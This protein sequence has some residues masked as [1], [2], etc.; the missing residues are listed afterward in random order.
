MALICSRRSLVFVG[1]GFC[2]QY[3][4]RSPVMEF[5]GREGGSEW[6][7]KD[8]ILESTE[9]STAEYTPSDVSKVAAF[10]KAPSS[11]RPC[12]VF[13][14]GNSCNRASLE[15]LVFLK[16]GVRWED[17]RGSCSHSSHPRSSITAWHL[18]R[19][20]L[21]NEWGEEV[22]PGGQRVTLGKRQRLSA[23]SHK[24]E[25]PVSRCIKMARQEHHG[26]KAERGICRRVGW[27]VLRIC[28]MR[29]DK[30]PGSEEMGI[31]AR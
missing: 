15:G 26:F 4:L 23:S 20:A 25:G 29:A 10:E 30:S 12:N 2:S 22:F 21:A 17:G 13:R 16:F 24:A 6:G 8:S 14:K 7:C 5:E 31:P 18:S 11:R 28:D 9:G 1:S 19:M 27:C 3:G